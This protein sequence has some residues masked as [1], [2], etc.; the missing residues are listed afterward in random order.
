MTLAACGSK[1]I[2]RGYN[3]MTAALLLLCALCSVWCQW[4]QH[5]VTAAAYP[6]EQSYNAIDILLTLLN[7][8]LS[9]KL[10]QKTVNKQRE[11]ETAVR[12]RQV[13]VPL[14]QQNVEMRLEIYTQLPLLPSLFYTE[15]TFCTI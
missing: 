9:C 5:N 8:S 4:T 14:N 2:K 11:Y 7:M 6:D 10:R 13:S 15:L 12:E 1:L 3:L